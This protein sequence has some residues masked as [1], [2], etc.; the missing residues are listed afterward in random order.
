M[1]IKFEKKNVVYVLYQID[2]AP[3]F[4]WIIDSLDKNKFNLTFILLGVDSGTYI[5]NYCINKNISYYRVD[6]YG[7]KD[8]VKCIIKFYKLFLKIKPDIVH[9]HLFE[10]CLIGL[11]AAKLLGIKKRIYTRHHSTYHHVYFPKA[12]K[13]DKYINSLATDIVAISEV[14]KDVLIDKENVPPN[15]I[16]LIHHGFNLSVF[17]NTDIQLVSQMRL[18]YNARKQR[19]VIGVI[20]RYIHWKGI[21]YAIDAFERL[22]HQFPDA[23]LI[24]ANARGQYKEAIQKKLNTIPKDNFIEIPFEIHVEALYRL[25]DIYIH[26]P[27]DKDAEAFGQTYVESLA[28]GIPMVATL[29]GVANE[30]LVDKKNALVVPYKDADSVYNAIIEILNNPVLREQLI[31]N[32]KRDVSQLFSLNLMI[33]K[34]TALYLK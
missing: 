5:E 27:I 16:S 24:L 21:E 10:A 30:F 18:K 3:A 6:Y 2:K 8:V 25:F 17:E 11:T 29:S 12:V 32:G 28:C 9:T 7:K 22:L 26:I 4:E 23:L 31:E 1:N 20:S 34:L 15:K 19:P 14:V 13:Y 33:E